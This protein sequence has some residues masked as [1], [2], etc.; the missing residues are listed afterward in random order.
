[1]SRWL[2][3]RPVTSSSPK[4]IFPDDGFWNP[5]IHAQRRGLAAAG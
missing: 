1:M 3:A 5:A 4:K 2:A